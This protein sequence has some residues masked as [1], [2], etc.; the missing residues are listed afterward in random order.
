M[1]LCNH[2]SISPCALLIGVFSLGDVAKM[3]FANDLAR[4]QAEVKDKHQVSHPRLYWSVVVVA[5]RLINDD[6]VKVVL[7]TRFH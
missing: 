7:G 3:A 4:G 6:L 1:M 5:S 2:A